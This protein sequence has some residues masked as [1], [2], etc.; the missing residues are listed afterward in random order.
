VNITFNNIIDGVTRPL[1][2]GTYIRA[3][4]QNSLTDSIQAEGWIGDNGVFTFPMQI[5]DTGN[6]FSRDAP[7]LYF[8]VE[9]RNN[10]GLTETHGTLARRH[11]W[12]TN[13]WWNTS[14]SAV[15]GM[16][17]QVSGSNAEA[18]L[19]RQLWYKINRVY[20]WNRDA[21]SAK[22]AA[23]PLDVL[24]PVST[25]AGVAPLARAAIRQLQIPYGDANN[26]TTLFHEFGHEVYYRQM[27]G[28]AQWATYDTATSFTVPTC[29][30]CLGHGYD[31]NSGPEAAMVEGWADFFEAVSTGTLGYNGPSAWIES[32]SIYPNIPTGL[33]NETRVAA[34][35]YDLYDNHAEEV[36]ADGQPRFANTR[37][38]DDNYRPGGLAS[39]RYSAVASYFF[40]GSL[41]SELQQN[42]FQ[43]IKPALSAG[44]VTEHCVLLLLNTLQ[45]VD[46]TCP[47][48]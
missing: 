21:M 4:E 41:S 29:G 5:C 46:R 19:A 16:T 9:T 14:P 33:G 13:T 15:N 12:R 23:F 47:Q 44:Q 40:N 11:W 38:D 26:T 7:D 10:I 36:N 6:L 28:A 37:N 1:P 24:Y 35:L 42:W 32:P 30:G 31:T 8:I 39:Q 27:L 22:Y 43:R 18:E 45:A 3:S 25:Y 48:Q 34:Y 2:K 20:D 17:V